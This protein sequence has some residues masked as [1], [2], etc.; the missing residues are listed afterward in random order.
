MEDR[1]FTTFPEVYPPK[2]KLYE[3]PEVLY[4]GL[5]RDFVTSFDMIFMVLLWVKKKY[6]PK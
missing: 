6:L 5:S 4:C 3:D 1:S 2:R